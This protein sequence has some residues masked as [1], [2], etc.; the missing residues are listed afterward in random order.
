MSTLKQVFAPSLKRNIVFGRKRPPL[1]IGPHLKASKYIGGALPAPPATCSYAS[2]AAQALAQMYGNDSLGDCV[3]AGGYHVVGVETGNAGKIFIA[4]QKQILADYGAIGGYVPG[5]PNTDN[6]C[7]EPTALN[8]WVNHG[9][10]DGTK[11]LG[12]LAVDPNNLTEVQQVLWLFEN[13]VFGIELPDAWINPFP[14]ASGFTWGVA[15]AADPE[16]GHCVIG[17]GYNSSGVQI[18]T[19]AMQGTIT[20]AALQKYCA[21]SVGGELYVLITPDQLP[22]AATKAPNGFAWSDLISDF[23][24]LGGHVPVPAPP[25]PTPPAPTPTPPAPTP[26]PPAPSTRTIVITGATKITIDGKVV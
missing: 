25:A 5:N 12:W 2:A 19:W 6:G 18:D 24:A 22:K 20:W 11:A 17:M 26:T 15:E 23:N 1:D 10:A 13:L 4:T 7:D 8:Y 3:I 14:S 9:F 21:S 16:N